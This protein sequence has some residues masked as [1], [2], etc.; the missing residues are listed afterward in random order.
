MLLKSREVPINQRDFHSEAKLQ[1]D[2]RLINHL[3]IYSRTDT[4]TMTSMKCHV[5]LNKV[6]MMC[7]MGCVMLSEYLVG[8]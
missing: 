5:E 1:T 2:D 6:I 3:L 8:L 7:L 4:Y